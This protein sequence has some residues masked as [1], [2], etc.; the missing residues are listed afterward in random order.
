MP[1]RTSYMTFAT[2]PV[3]QLLTAYQE[4]PRA[5]TDDFGISESGNGIPDAIDEVKWETDRLRRMQDPDGS[6]ALKVG[7]TVWRPAD[8]P[9]RDNARRLYVPACTSATIAAAGMFVAGGPVAD[10]VA[11]GIPASI[12][13]PAG[14]PPQKS[15]RDWNG[16]SPQ[17]SWIV[18]KAGIHYQSGYVK[19]L[20]AF[21]Q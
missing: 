17:N 4:N 3:H 21:A 10:A 5:F 1:A 12:V 15:Y 2:Q 14:Q 19:L 11:A 6:S 20:P 7:E 9:S 13:P 8:P 16:G 18:A